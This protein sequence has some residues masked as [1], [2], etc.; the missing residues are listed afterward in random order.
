[1]IS[2]SLYCLGRLPE[3]L[4][5][6]ETV[7]AAPPQEQEELLIDYGL[8]PRVGAA[9]YSA[10]ALVQMGMEQEGLARHEL[11]LALA[12]KHLDP[13]AMAMALGASLTFHIRR[14]DL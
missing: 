12:E 6:A 4:W 2:H 13:F 5:H 1:A 11:A 14:H 8:P 10:W 9:Y 7:L 3:C